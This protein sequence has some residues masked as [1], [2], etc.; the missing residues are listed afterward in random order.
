MQTTITIMTCDKCGVE[1]NERANKQLL[2]LHYVE[3]A[4]IIDAIVSV[5]FSWRQNGGK[6][7]QDG[8]LCPKCVIEILKEAVDKLEGE[9]DNHAD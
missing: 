8:D 4:E 5:T 7:I 3:Q 1:I 6:D 9:E 2:R